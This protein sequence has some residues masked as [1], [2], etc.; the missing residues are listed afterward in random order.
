MRK[1]LRARHIRSFSGSGLA[2]LVIEWL[3]LTQSAGS[4]AGSLLGGIGLALLRLCLVGVGWVC[5]SVSG[6]VT[7]LSVAAETVDLVCGS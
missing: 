1:F 5:E 6:V 3:A 7:N 4:V 2:E